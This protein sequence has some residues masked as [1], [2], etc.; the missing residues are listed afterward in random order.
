MTDERAYRA[1]VERLRARVADSVPRGA[2]V[3]VI[4]R[5]DEA[6]L[7]LRGCD[8][9]H[10][11]QSPT[12][13]Y[14]GHHPS[15]GREATRHLAE[16]RDRGAEYLVVPATAAWWL[17]HYPELR[18][19]LERHGEL[20]AH[21]PDTCAVYALK[22][23]AARAPAPTRDQLEA[24]RTAPQQGALVR[25]LLPP[26]AGVAL[27]GRSAAEVD[28]GGRPLWAIP[29][30]GSDVSVDD[31]LWRVDVAAR[32]GARYVA[33]LHADAASRQLDGRLRARLARWHRPV[34]AQ[35]LAEVFELAGEDAAGA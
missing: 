27:V 4:S 3:L 35:R 31:V 30:P 12:G 15:D 2:A 16:L 6:L 28:V 17:D 7:R 19:D 10:F 26:Q 21:E 29:A 32:E 24:A 20:V 8:A 22:R 33:L 18:A 1:L 14:A 5:G 34:F 25:A 23:R 11:P 9:Q 13:L